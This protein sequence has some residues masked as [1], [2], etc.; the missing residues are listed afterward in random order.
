MGHMTTTQL[1]EMTPADIDAE[2]GR[3][4]KAEQSSRLSLATYRKRAEK[5]SGPVA[6][7]YARIIT[8][9]EAEVTS[10]RSEAEPFEAEFTARGGW[11]RYFLVQNDGGH[12][13][14]EMNCTTCYATT[15]F[16]WLPTLSGCDE[17]AMVAEYG[18]VACTV[19][20]PNA[21]TYRGFGDGLSAIA[22]YTAVEKA[23]RAAEK[24][25]KDAAK[26]EKALVE[27]IRVGY[28]TL[29]TVVAARNY[30]SGRT[31]DILI[32]TDSDGSGHPDQAEWEAGI[33][34]AEEALALKGWTPE[35]IEKVK[36]NA[37]KKVAAA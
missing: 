36:A 5:A 20:F 33:A 2:L 6:A 32:Y 27:P 10:L 26:A 31:Q 15:Q 8:K 11:S 29:R 12:V 1:T 21:P 16:A 14:R 23:Q 22:R 13:H 37:R 17:A 4:W 7:E 19:C 18:E 3:I 25:G 28:D 9:V 24:A 34:L 30:I 35:Q